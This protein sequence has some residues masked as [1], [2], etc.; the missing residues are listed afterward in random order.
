MPAPTDGLAEVERLL[1]AAAGRATRFPYRVGQRHQV[2]AR[3]RGW[4]ELAIVAHDVPA[5]GGGEAE[6]VLLTEIV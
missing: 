2:V 1:L 3:R 4:F 5:A 6:G